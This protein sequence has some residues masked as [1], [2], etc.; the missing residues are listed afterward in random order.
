MG[1][2]QAGRG[3]IVGMIRGDIAL[4]ASLHKALSG[5]PEIEAFT[6]GLSI[7]TFRYV[8]AG[9]AGHGKEK[10][11]Y[12]DRLN[13]ELLARLQEGGELFVSSAQ[14]EGKSLLR[15][16]IVNFRTDEVDVRAIPGIVARLGREVHRELSGI[17]A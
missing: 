14:V 10:A 8:P 4:A 9:L 6:T 11:E 3:G 1:M 2:K 5:H 12:L 15:A 7:V 13:T 17:E 16:C